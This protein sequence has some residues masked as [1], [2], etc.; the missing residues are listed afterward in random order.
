MFSLD[1]HMNPHKARQSE[2]AKKC[3]PSPRV[4]PL[5]PPT[6]RHATPLNPSVD[7]ADV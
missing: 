4:H 5:N 1:L 7:T 2:T 3:G 6:R